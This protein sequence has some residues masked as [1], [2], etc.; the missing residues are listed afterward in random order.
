VSQVEDVV[1]EAPQSRFT[2]HSDI[3]ETMFRLPAGSEASV[4]GRDKDHPVV[5]E[6]YQAA[7]FHAL[8]KVLYPT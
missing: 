1:F 6:G 2:E 7:H 8:L 4:E 3:F 5:L